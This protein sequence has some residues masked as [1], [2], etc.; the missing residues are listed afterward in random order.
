MTQDRLRNIRSN[1]DVINT[2]GLSR[3]LLIVPRADGENTMQRRAFLVAAAGAGLVASSAA[4]AQGFGDMSSGPTQVLMVGGLSLQTSQL[5]LQRSRNSQIRNFAQLEA[6]EQTAVAAALGAQPGSVPLSQDQAAMYQQLAA[7][8]GHQF[9][10][11]YVTGQIEGHRQLL[12]L[13]T[14]AAQGGG[15]G[16][17][18]I[19]ATVSV[20]S[21]Q[22]H[23]YML[24][25]LRG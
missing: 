21:I 14:A 8:S 20:P 1:A 15:D 3:A 24:S 12:E 17:S 18:R 16:A 4:K 5:A 23:L 9:D 13:N 22:T 7:L 6:N 10:R 25:H 19:V 11:M 2:V